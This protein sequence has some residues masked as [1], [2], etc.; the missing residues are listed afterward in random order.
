MY[1]NCN[2]CLRITCDYLERRS[3]AVFVFSVLRLYS[4]LCWTQHDVGYNRDVRCD[5]K[6]EKCHMEI[7]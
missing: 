3:R 4:A 5:R 7:I 1:E 6:S 2:K